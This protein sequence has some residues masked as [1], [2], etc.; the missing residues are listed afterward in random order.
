MI[1]I[2]KARLVDA[3]EI[4]KLVKAGHK[5]KTWQYT[6]GNSYGKK[7]YEQLTKYLSDKKSNWRMFVA[8]E[9]KTKTIV[10]QIG[11]GFRTD[12]RRRHIVSLGWGVYPG[13]ENQGIG[14][15]LLKFALAHAKKRGFKRAEAEAAIENVGSWKIAQKCGFKIEGTKRKGLLLDNGRYADLYVLGKLL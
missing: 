2:R 7:K 6:G 10:G 4:A 9:K 1:T 15:K 13:Y 14:T 11:Y 5:Q 3:P 8:I 12:G